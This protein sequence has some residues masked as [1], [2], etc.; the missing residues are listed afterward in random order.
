MKKIPDET[1]NCIRNYYT[2][3][4]NCFIC[5]GKKQ[6]VTTKDASGT[7]IM[8][9]K[10]LLTQ[11][12]H[13]LYLNFKEEFSDKLEIMPKFSFFAGL[14]PPQCITAGDPGSHNI[15]VC[16]QHENVKLKLKAWNN[17]FSYRDLLEISVCDPNS[18]ECM[19]HKCSK[20]P[21][22][23]KIKEMTEAI[24]SFSGESITFK[25]WVEEG[26]KASLVTLVEPFEKFKENL[27]EQIWELTIHHFIS[28]EQKRYLKSSKENLQNDT[29]I[30]IMDFSENYS[31]IIQNSTQ[32]FYYNNRQATNNRHSRCI[33]KRMILMNCKTKTFA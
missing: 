11:T 3:E 26:S 13:D 21:G 30:L 15:C 4:N 27:F 8:V 6:Y 12:V 33:S 2:D 9:Q 1:I 7:K 10:R 23:P 24:D 16:T 31:F 17:S 28:D 20:C 19:L 5:P 29:C 25:N 18:I 14:R 22:I 32:A